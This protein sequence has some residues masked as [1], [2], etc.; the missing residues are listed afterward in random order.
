MAQKKLL[1]TLKLILLM[2]T[3][4]VNAVVASD[5][6]KSNTSSVIT[7]DIDNIIQQ[8]QKQLSQVIDLNHPAQD[9][10]YLFIST[11]LPIKNLEILL[12][13]A[14]KHDFVPIMRGLKE[15]SFQKTHNFFTQIV[16][17]TDYGVIIEPELFKEFN[18]KAV[19]SFVNAPA[20]SNCLPN[21]NC[22]RP[23]NVIS[24][25]ITVAK[26]WQLLSE[27]GSKW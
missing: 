1:F 21:T 3:M 17:K 7:A 16:K 9:K 27:R 12:I 14:K 20:N 8:Q 22:R 18:I 15:D 25:N 13:E 24:G 19:P 23:F 4:L 11:S 26:A 6:I 10:K 5:D 2:L